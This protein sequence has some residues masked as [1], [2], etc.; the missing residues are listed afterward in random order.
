MWEEEKTHSAV[1]SVNYIK[2]MRAEMTDYNMKSNMNGYNN[3][4]FTG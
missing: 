4:K 2:I 3:I 1:K